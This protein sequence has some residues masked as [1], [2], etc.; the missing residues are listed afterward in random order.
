M[1]RVALGRSVERAASARV[2]PRTYLLRSRSSLRTAY[3]PLIATF[4]RPVDARW[5]CTYFATGATPATD[6]CPIIQRCPWQAQRHPEQQL[7]S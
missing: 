2:P 4:G 6:A 7:C 5:S 3:Q 1:S